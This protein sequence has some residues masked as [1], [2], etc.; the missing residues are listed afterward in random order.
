MVARSNTPHAI[1]PAMFFKRL[2]E[3]SNKIRKAKVAEV[4]KGWRACNSELHILTEAEVKSALDAEVKKHKR[5]LMIIRL[6][7]R[8]SALRTV[9]ERAELLKK[10]GM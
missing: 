3:M 8:F 9:R 4:L 5:K 1:A 7:A 10:A 6:H 2:K